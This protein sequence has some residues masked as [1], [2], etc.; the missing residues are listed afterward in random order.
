VSAVAERTQ[1]ARRRVVAGR[2]RPWGWIV[3]GLLLIAGFAVIVRVGHGTTFYFDEW[4]FVQ[5][6]RAWNADALLVPHNEHLSLLP[7][8][9]YKLLFA[10]VG[11]EHY[12]AYRI[13]GA[14]FH[15]LCVALLFA[16]ARRRVGDLL[17]LAASITLLF[18]GSGYIDILWPFQIGFL[19]SLAAGLVALLALDRED[20]RGD[21]LAA[22]ALAVALASSSIGIPFLIAVIVELAGRR[23]RARWW[24]AAAPLALYALWFATY[25]SK[26]QSAA[27]GITA[28]N[29]FDT[30]AYVAQ[31]AAGAAGAL[32]GLDPDWGRSLIVALVL[33]VALGAALGAANVF[34]WR[35]AALAALPLAFWALTGATRASINE[36]TASRYLYPGALFLLLLGIEAAR[37]RR[38][39]A[40]LLAV[41]GV[42]VLGT[43][44]ANA[45][46][47]RD[48]ARAQRDLATTLQGSL[49]A[50]AVAGPEL[51]GRFVPAPA[52]APQIRLGP[53][54]AAVND[55]GSPVPPASELPGTFQASRAA[56]DEVL[57]R[58]Y[59]LSAVAA[60]VPDGGGA[61]PVERAEGATQAAVDG[62][63]LARPQ[64]AAPAITVT[65]PAG[66]LVLDP[67]QGT[68][69]VQ[70]RRWSDTGTELASRA[71]P[72]EPV[73][74][75]IP[76]DAAQAPW[77]AR[78]AFRAPVRICSGTA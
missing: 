63:L 78:V 23:D 29:L 28:D 48:G 35:L 27:N 54:R 70:L 67:E 71:A 36:P 10:T 15:L 40:P 2:E 65:V 57:I 52:V 13:A 55:L 1:W 24:V 44:V 30:P 62:C 8:L 7:V 58:G 41:L 75:R 61:P 32:F 49:A 26:G 4:D 21:V 74:I 31:A 6:R 39:P 33:A 22:L 66:G 56:A 20:R 47:L 60:P 72:G 45:G 19:A 9:V 68:A 5:N 76:A 50:A 11:L 51:P 64:G 42:L 12:A 53:Y 14:L 16:Y 37:G 3:L 73:A 46:Q 38:A 18:L 17:A 69:S 25:R 77:H 59:G 43:T 34:S